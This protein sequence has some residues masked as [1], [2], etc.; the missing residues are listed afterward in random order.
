[1]CTLFVTGVHEECY[2]P[3]HGTVVLP[4]PNEFGKWVH[5]STIILVNAT[6]NNLTLT[7]VQYSDSGTYLHDTMEQCRYLLSIGGTV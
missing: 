3:L 2:A 4:C 7:D 6:S 5:N 1:M